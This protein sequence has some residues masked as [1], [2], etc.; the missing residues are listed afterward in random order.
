MAKRVS[1][2]IFFK[3]FRKFL[4]LIFTVE[5]YIMGETILPRIRPFCKLIQ[6][7]NLSQLYFI[8]LYFDRK[9]EEGGIASNLLI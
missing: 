1:I 6:K 9:K 8:L 3:N 4:K 2:E 5:K 7:S